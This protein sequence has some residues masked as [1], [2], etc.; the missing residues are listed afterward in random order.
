[1]STWLM[2]KDVDRLAVVPAS[3]VGHTQRVSSKIY[4]IKVFLYFSPSV[5]L[6][7]QKREK[8]HMNIK[9]M[10]LCSMKVI[11]NT[12]TFYG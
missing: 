8:S 3:A 10:D 6:V 7:I 5:L 9:K 4:N 1:M 11:L 2:S 12:N